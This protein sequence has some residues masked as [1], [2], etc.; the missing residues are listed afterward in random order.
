MSLLSI[1]LY[2]VK[3]AA[4]KDFLGTVQR[5]GEMGYDAV[6]FAG[7]FNTNSNDLRRVLDNQNLKCGGSHVLFDTIESSELLKK[8]IEYNQVIGNN[9]IICA[10]LPAQMRDSEEGYK[11]AAEQLNKAGELCKEQGLQL[12]Y[13]NHSFEFVKIKDTTGFELLYNET[14]SEL[15]KM[16]LDCY[17]VKNAGYD[18]IDFIN[19]YTDRCISLHI[20]DIKK[21][22]DQHISVEIGEGELN[23]SSILL[24]ASKQQVKYLTVEQEHFI[25]DPMVSAE[26]NIKSLRHLVSNKLNK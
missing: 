2:S 18:P 6:Q 11:R 7:F 1:Q 4:N 10:A 19:R 16:E 9:L 15:L 8:E 12:G 25:L 3:E 24:S 21:L 23:L 22:N 26:K 17:W 5:V 14:S 20:K 13:H